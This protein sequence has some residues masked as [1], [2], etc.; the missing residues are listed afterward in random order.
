MSRER[1]GGDREEII[2]RGV[3]VLGLLCGGAR[4]LCVCAGG[5]V[6]SKRFGRNQRRKM[7]EEIADLKIEVDQCERL[8]SGVRSELAMYRDVANRTAEV[9]GNYFISLPAETM[10]VN[11]IPYYFNFPNPMPAVPVRPWEY[12]AQ[13]MESL[14]Y[15]ES[16][17]MAGETTF[18]N[19]RGQMHVKFS[20]NCGQVA[21]AV[22]RNAFSNMQTGYAIR[23]VASGLADCLVRMED[24]RRFTGLKPERVA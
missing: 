1:I 5:G 4:G 13:M 15:I 7:R 10:G 3:G 16:T 6:M 20:S 24:F 17:I 11:R 2:N 18:D 19:L 8:L 23:A 12:P 14:N 21:Y 22:S 9:L